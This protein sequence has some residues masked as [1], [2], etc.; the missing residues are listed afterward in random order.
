[1]ITLPYSTAPH[2]THTH[3]RGQH[4]AFIAPLPPP[5]TSS[6]H[7]YAT[8]QAAASP[9]ALPL[10]STSH[11]TPSTTP[12]RPITLLPPI[13]TRALSTCDLFL[14]LSG[15]G[16]AHCPPATR[17]HDIFQL[18]ELDS[19]IALHQLQPALNTLPP[20]TAYRIALGQRC[21]AY[22]DSTPRISAHPY[23]RHC[24]VSR[25]Q[26]TKASHSKHAKW[27]WPAPATAPDQSPSYHRAIPAGLVANDTCSA[28]CG[29]SI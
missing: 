22:S 4:G 13:H 18:S 5:S 15:H 21:V 6:T 26:S 3:P 16:K 24:L 29:L 25:A 11:L 23:A 7:E 12:L 9:A 20:Y 10:L 1:M 28:Q 17:V 8:R 14:R 2:H 19:W 27:N